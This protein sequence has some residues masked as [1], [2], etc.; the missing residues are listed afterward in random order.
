LLINVVYAQQFKFARKPVDKLCNFLKHRLASSERAE[1]RQAQKKEKRE[2]KMRLAIVLE[3]CM[4]LLYGVMYSFARDSLST[5]T[6]KTGL[7]KLV[8]SA[9]HKQY[10]VVPCFVLPVAGC[11]GH[12][13]P[14]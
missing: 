1:P 8:C 12:E 7:C 14:R 6:S 5:R 4:G 11:S 2:K 10:Q 9:Q 13:L 3:V